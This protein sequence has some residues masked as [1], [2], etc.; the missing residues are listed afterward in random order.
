M[1]KISKKIWV[2][3]TT[4]GIT[5]IQLIV[6]RLGGK[7]FFW[8]SILMSIIINMLAM[9]LINC[10]IKWLHDKGR[11]D[12]SE[13]YLRNAPCMFQAIK[14][15]IGIILSIAIALINLMYKIEGIDI[16]KMIFPWYFLPL[17]L[18]FVAIGFMDIG[19]YDNI[20]KS[21]KIMKLLLFPKKFCLC[22]FDY[23]KDGKIIITIKSIL[24]TMALMFLVITVVL[25]FIFNI[26]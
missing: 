14:F 12:A 4:I 26:F 11:D 10:S 6:P 9:V 13:I 2:S 21:E 24:S 15:S 16:E 17:L 5:V 1:K 8:Y 23:N 22:M 25:H 7:P 3:K 19:L 20:P 18:L